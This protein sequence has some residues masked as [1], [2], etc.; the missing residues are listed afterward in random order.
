MAELDALLDAVPRDAIGL[1]VASGKEGSFIAGADIS[2]ID[3]IRDHEFA[4][5][6]AR[7]GQRILSKLAA[8][9]MPTVAA[10]SGYCLGGGFELALACKYR[11]AALGVKVQIG[12]PETKLGILPGFGGTQRLPKIVGI[13]KA[14]EMILAGTLVDVERAL[15][16]GLVDRA[17]APALLIDTAIAVIREGR[18]TASPHLD[19]AGRILE[20]KTFRHVLRPLGKRES[21]QLLDRALCAAEKKTKGNYPAMPMTVSVLKRTV[22]LPADPLTGVSKEGLEIEAEG[23]AQLV[24][25]EVSIN[26]RTLYFLDDAEKKYAPYTA[27]PHEIRRAAVLGAG[28]MGGGIAWAF[29]SRSIPVRVKDIRP[30]AL[31]GA[32]AAAD[33]VYR[34][35]V[36]RR[37]MKPGAAE[38]AMSRISTGLDYSGFGIADLVVEAVVE[39]MGVKKAV[40]TELEQSV[41]SDTVIATNTSG[42]SI[43]EMA[44][45][46]KRPERFG[47]LHFFNP[48][49]RMPLV[50]I[51]RGSSTS[52]ST[53]ATL[54]AA[55]RR[56]GKTP[57]LVR[58][59]PGFLVNRILI[60]YM[61]EAARMFEEGVSI[62][63]I[64]DVA[65]KFGMPM[66]PM[67]LADEVGL[68]IGLHVAEHLE[69]SF[70]ERMK[71]PEILRTMVEK[72]LLGRKTGK[73]FYGH[74]RNRKG[75]SI[76]TVNAEIG[77]RAGAPDITE[78]EIEDRLFLTMYLEAVRCL[79]DKIVDRTDDV[80]IGMIYG[81]GFPPFRG[82]LLRWGASL[83]HA[84]LVKCAATL[85]EKYGER[86]IVPEKAK[87]LF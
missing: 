46:L 62:K 28:I 66:G 48:V 31:L 82:G 15:R 27:Q 65:E 75:E 44:R 71:V 54:F 56:L 20:S 45:A 43:N 42:L 85:R 1:V 10:I 32:L 76:A 72:K 74:S 13:R 17:S 60:P 55:A 36:K 86:Y 33:S 5:T 84:G 3:S 64:D 16:M 35:E 70:G 47:G 30:E 38:R 37:K 59:S 18:K 40:L 68:D 24:T 12:L 6:K 63:E 87:T 58:D 73:G 9:P 67:R 61:L 79:E 2:E 23:F 34:F 78:F 83:G 51:I 26:L 22:D 80:E 25:T 53:V 11:V 69:L 7:E 49:H 41:R 39:K 50:E 19:L 4:K 57:I 81:T 8:L 14:A 52:D 29:S 77:L 21:D